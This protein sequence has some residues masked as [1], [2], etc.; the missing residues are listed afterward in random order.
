[1]MQDMDGVFAAHTKDDMNS[2]SGGNG[3]A[4]RGV[5]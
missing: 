3:R 5:Q 4:G 2:C 1:M